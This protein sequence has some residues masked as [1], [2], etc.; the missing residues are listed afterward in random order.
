MELT[1]EEGCG[2]WRF[3]SLEKLLELEN[4]KKKK[5]PY[6]SRWYL[7]EVAGDWECCGNPSTCPILML[8]LGACF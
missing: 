5:K 1:A 4:L 2:C 7:M 3:M 6:L 8:S